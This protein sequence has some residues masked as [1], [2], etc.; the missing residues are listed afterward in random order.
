MH[1]RQE[2][3]ISTPWAMHQDLAPSQESRATTRDVYDD[4]TRSHKP[5][6]SLNLMSIEHHGALP[7]GFGLLLTLAYLRGLT[8]QSWSCT[9]R[10]SSRLLALGIPRVAL[11][12]RGRRWPR[13]GHSVSVAR[14]ACRCTGLDTDGRG[15]GGGSVRA[16]QGSARSGGWRS[17]R[18]W[19]LGSRHSP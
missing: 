19:P 5:P 16:E 15:P 9:A 10:A 12:R 1:N 13:P 8:V 11:R 4:G 3:T 18:R 14:P 7:P 17:A 6:I 2:R